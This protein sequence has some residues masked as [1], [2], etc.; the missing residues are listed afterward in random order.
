MSI[1][2][3]GYFKSD[4]KVGIVILNYNGAKDTIECLESIYK[5]TNYKRSQ[6]ILVDNAS[7]GND[8]RLIEKWKKETGYDFIF[9]RN[10]ENLGF[11]G[12]VNVGIKKALEEGADYIWLLNNDTVVEKDTLKNLLLAFD[13][14]YNIG[15]VSSKIYSYFDRSKVQFNG[16]KSCYIGSPDKDDDKPAFMD[17]APVCSVLISKE[18]FEKIG[19]FNEDYFLYF[20][21]N[22]FCKRLKDAG[23]QLLYYPF[24]KVYHKGGAS[25]GSWL[26]SPISAYYATRNLLYFGGDESEEKLMKSFSDIEG[27]Y[28]INLGKE[29]ECIKGFVEG[30]KDYILRKKGK[31]NAEQ[32]NPNFWKDWP[33]KELEKKAK[34]LVDSVDRDNFVKFLSVAKDIS[35]KNRKQSEAYKLCKKGEEEYEKGNIDKAISL[36]EKAIKIDNTCYTAHSNL[37]AIYWQMGSKVLASCFIER[38]MELAPD[39][40]DVIWN[41]EQIKKVANG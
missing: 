1:Y 2:N 23:F 20:E 12:G 11:A 16:K 24:S 26:K 27:F 41:Y 19:F 37:A 13:Q 17:L 4:S 7:K 32:L 18:V 36:F 14:P 40:P 9:I 29:P 15:M 39:D 6:V 25:I 30:I 10:P 33:D 8:I 21:D 5:N 22:D 3:G 28:W 34:K 31:V 35:L 38:A